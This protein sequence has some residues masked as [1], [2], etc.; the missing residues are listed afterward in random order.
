MCA[1]APVPYIELETI[2]IGAVA[3]PSD[4]QVTGL[5]GNAASLFPKSFTLISKVPF[6]SSR[7][8]AR[9]DRRSPGSRFRCRLWLR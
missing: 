8:L 6:D 1:Y 3:E 9:P 2:W 7:T 5:T 4:E